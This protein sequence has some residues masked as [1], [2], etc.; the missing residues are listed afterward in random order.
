MASTETK[1]DPGIVKAPLSLSEI[2]ALLVKSYGLHTGIFEVAVEFQIAVGAVGPN[3]G[4]I[5]PGAIVG[6]SKIGLREAKNGK[7]GPGLVDASVVNPAPKR[8]KAKAAK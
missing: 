4:N 2:G 3:E 7:P 1:N 5:F 6:V 8:G